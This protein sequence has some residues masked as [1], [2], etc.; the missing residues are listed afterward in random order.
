MY[1]V[2]AQLQQL[3]F[4]TVEDLQEGCSDTLHTVV[5]TSLWD[6]STCQVLMNAQTEQEVEAKYIRLWNSHQQALLSKYFQKEN[7]SGKGS[8]SALVV[9]KA[10]SVQQIS[11]SQLQVYTAGKVHSWTVGTG[12]QQVSGSETPPLKKFLVTP[13]LSDNMAK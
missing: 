13:K 3:F 12:P 2:F 8:M 4:K 7:L 1:L 10:S 9:H 5:L 6:Q 11:R